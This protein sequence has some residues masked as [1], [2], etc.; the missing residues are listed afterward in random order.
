MICSS[1]S[2]FNTEVGSLRDMFFRNSYPIKF[3]QSV[4]SAFLHVSNLNESAT[5]EVEE[6][7]DTPIVILRVPYLGKCSTVFAR[8]LSSIIS[9]HFHVKVNI[10]Y[11]TFKVKSYFSLKCFSPNYLSSYIA[12]QFK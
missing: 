2:L 4:Y 5:D 6:K 8:S 12:Y 1:V 10:V 11:C 3:F 7:D 9:N